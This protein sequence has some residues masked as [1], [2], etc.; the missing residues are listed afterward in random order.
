MFTFSFRIE[1]DHLRQRQPL[2]HNKLRDYRS[3][4]AACYS[5]RVELFAILARI[6][7]LS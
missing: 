1:T 2:P 6:N 7:M 4:V 5:L 3:R